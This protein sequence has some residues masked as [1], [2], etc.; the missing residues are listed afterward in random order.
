MYSCLQQT[1]SAMVAITQK[2]PSAKLGYFKKGAA[3]IK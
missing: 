2:P 3:P 1:I